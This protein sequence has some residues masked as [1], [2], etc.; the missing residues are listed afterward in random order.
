MAIE[1]NTP[2][3]LLRHT[4]ATVAYRGGKTLRGAPDSFASF[5]AAPECRTGGEILAHIGDLFDWAITISQG[6][7]VWHDSTPRSWPAECTRFF[8]SLKRFDDLLASE[9]ELHETPE[10][11]FQGPVADALTHIGQLA[12]LRRLS[13]TAIKGEN[14]HKAEISCGC[15]GENQPPPRREF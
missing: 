12:M 9:A 14:Y 6:K 4:L 10:K 2:R 11:L 7:P 5:R 13:G 8:E 3:S 15:V 1:T